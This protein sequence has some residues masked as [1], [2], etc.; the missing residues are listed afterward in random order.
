M[1]PVNLFRIVVASPGD[2]QVERDTLP[3]VP[4]ALPSRRTWG[5]RSGWWKSGL[6]PGRG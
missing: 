2:V 6:G 3:A 1:E 5:K 4:Q